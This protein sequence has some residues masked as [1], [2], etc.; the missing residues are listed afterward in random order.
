[1]AAADACSSNLIFFR[2]VVRGRH[3]FGR[4]PFFLSMLPPV[5]DISGHHNDTGAVVANASDLVAADL[6]PGMK[7]ETPECEAVLYKDSMGERSS[8]VIV[9]D[10]YTFARLNNHYV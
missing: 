9:S 8:C 6:C 10:L 7:N 1:M 2:I 4:Q 3:A 5:H